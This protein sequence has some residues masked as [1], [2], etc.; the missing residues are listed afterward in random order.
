[1]EKLHERTI[2][3]CDEY[4]SW[5]DGVKKLDPSQHKM[6]EFIDLLDGGQFGWIDT[7]TCSIDIHVNIMHVKE[8]FSI[9]RKAISV[10]GKISGR[11]IVP[12]EK[13]FD[14][15]FGDSLIKIKFFLSGTGC[16]LVDTGEPIE[17]TRY[18]LVCSNGND[19]EITPESIGE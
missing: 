1:M 13:R 11:D 7:W 19:E 8:I 2:A 14:F 9:L 16:V 18:K 5:M 3:R 4:Q 17:I 10:F 6:D 12:E 15:D